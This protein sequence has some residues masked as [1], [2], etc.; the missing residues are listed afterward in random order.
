[1]T[2]DD[3]TNDTTTDDDTGT[4]RSAPVDGF[5]LAY[6]VLGDGPRSVVLLHGW[7]GDRSDYRL[8]APRLAEHATVV[9]PD[10]R[11]FGESDKH[12][13]EPGEA[14]GGDSQAR[15]IA[16]LIEQLQ[17]D[18]PVVA[19]YDV[20]SVVA[21]NLARTRPELVS[22]L[23]LSPPMPGVG[24]RILDPDSV[25]EFWYQAFHNLQLAQQL[26]DGDRDAVR[27]YL[28]HFWSHWSGPDFTLDDADLEHL[29]EVY[30]PPG[31]FVAS[32]NWYR[33]GAGSIARSRTERTPDPQRRTST[34]LDVLWPEHD[35]LFPRVWSDRLDDW[36][37]DVTLHH[38][39][40]SGHFTPI[41]ATDTFAGL[42][43]DALA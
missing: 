21:Q 1:M 34:P 35:P 37:S 41:E 15:S 6:D 11:G 18:R 32:V 27:A 26:V 30:S 14:Y 5:R 38:A 9:V 4:P 28:A 23:V 20:G 39:D 24:D 33:A 19:G 40:G 25:P 12:E 8:L 13:R 17:L 10:L 22:R 31:A 43:L 29:V 16:A 3:T 7:P 42:I 36:F 2:A